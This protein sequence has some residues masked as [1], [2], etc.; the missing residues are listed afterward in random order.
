M[1]FN[2]LTG[3]WDIETPLW[4]GGATW[5]QP[6]YEDPTWTA[7]NM[8]PSPMAEAE[9]EYWE[10]RTPQEDWARMMADLPADPRWRR[11]FES[12]GQ[13]RLLGRY[14]LAR[15]FMATTATDPDQPTS[16]AQFLSDLGGTDP[17]IT[18]PQ[19]YQANNLAALVERAR[20]AGR[21]AMMP[22]SATPE[23]MDPVRQAYYGTFGG[24]GTDAM[25]AQTAVTQMI[26]RQR[27]GGG[28]FR[29][30]LGDAIGRAMSAMSRA[31]QAKGAPEASFL[32]WYIGQRFPE[33]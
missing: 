29:G 22:T 3:Q 5:D 4:G 15:P 16:F 25:N 10:A 18:G 2:P 20:L 7:A 9:A 32:D 12:M 21:S 6:R 1:P 33:E 14:H 28:A 23:L 27:A 26:A 8:P 17:R 31:R 30:G 13:N 24:G 11:G 19:G